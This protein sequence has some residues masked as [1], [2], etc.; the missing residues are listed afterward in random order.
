MG[1][2]LRLSSLLSYQFSLQ[3][4]TEFTHLLPS[5][6]AAGV[7]PTVGCRWQLLPQSPVAVP[8]PSHGLCPLYPGVSM[9]IPS[10]SLLWAPLRPFG[11][12]TQVLLTLL[13][14][15]CLKVVKTPLQPEAGRGGEE[16]FG[17]S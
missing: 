7:M 17:G 3:I 14:E 10:S 13:S 2:C 11:G 8:V 12:D 9:P 1:S 6:R 15:L 4:L 5:L 16:G